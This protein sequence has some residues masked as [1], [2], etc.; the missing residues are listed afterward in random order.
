[1]VT[2]T[3]T[4]KK[5]K[6]LEET[7]YNDIAK[8]LRGT[9]E[10]AEYK[11]V[12]LPLLFLKFISEKFE[13]QKEK[14]MNEG[15]SQ[16]LEMKEFYQKDNV[17][18]LT[19]DTR[20]S[21]LVKNAKAND[22]AL[23]LDAALSTIEKTNP[24]LRGALPDNYYSRVNLSSSKIAKL[25]DDINNNIN[26]DD[27]S[28]DLMG[29]IYEYFLQK[30]AVAEGKSKGEFYT[31]KSTVNLITE[32]I[33][34]YSGKIYD[35]CCGSGGMFVQSLKFIEAHKGD[36]KNVAIYGQENID[37]TYRLAKMNLALRGISG[38]LGLT[39]A[40]T[41]S[42]DQ[43]KDLKADYI[44]ANPPFNLKDWRA[45]SEMVGDPR[46]AGYDVPPVSNANYA[47]ILNIVSKLSTNGTAGFLLAN[48]ALSDSDTKK[49]RQRLIENDLIEAIV[50]LPRNTFYSTDISVT[51]WILSKNKQSRDLK[52]GDNVR[53]LRNRKGEILFMDLRTWGSEFEK[54]YTE[55]TPSD[56]AKASS[57]FHA[58]QEVDGDYK[59]T[60]ETCRSAN[61]DTIKTNDFSLIP[62]R[63]I[64]FEDR[65]SKLNFESEMKRIQ[66]D[67]SD[68]LAEESTAAK[69]LRDAFEGLGYDL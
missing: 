55:L 7:L 5:T 42:N 53:H 50:V 48:G 25:I 31:P 59:D 37:T 60:A 21:Y 51:L 40:D 67:V 20:W 24:S 39:N 43:H 8:T 19:E 9:V 35:P 61:F 12:T 10:A 14:L 46:W 54:K 18:Y 15:K 58:W 28:F 64:E 33:E 16:F 30:F 69:T 27:E 57:I 29:R 38:N 36:T 66:E 11:H 62:S 63:Y 2:K 13:Q 65:D 6:S 47:W 68:I 1:M 41:F 34:P 52:V 23:K 4:S 22:I 32:M 17:F 3:S 45:E 56:I 44:I 26:Y 49:I